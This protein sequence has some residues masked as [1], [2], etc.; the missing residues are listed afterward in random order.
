MD[1]SK[2]E[3]KR[4][5]ILTSATGAGHDTHANATTAWCAQFYGP[6]VEVIIDH[7]LEDSHPIYGKAVAFYNF[8]QRYMPWFHHIYYNVIE[9]LE[10]LN[11]G[12]VSLGRDYYIQLLERIR[13]HAVISVMDCLNRGYFELATSVLGPD[14]KCATY[15]TEFSD[16]YGHSRNWVNPRCGYFFGR[17]EDTVRDARRRGVPEERTLVVGHWA[18]P[19]FYVPPPTAEEK[20]T[21]LRDTLQLDADK[22][23]LLLSTGGNGAQNHAD[24]LRTLF[25]LGDRIQVIALCGRNA[26]ARADLDAWVEREAPFQVRTLPFTDE[27]AKLFH[28]SSAVVARG[29]ATSAGEVLLCNCPI[30]FNGLGLMMPQELPT[31]R[32]FRDHKIGFRA[33][34]AGGF[35]PIIERWLD[36]PEE[37]AALRQRMLELRNATTPQAALERLLV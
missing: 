35:R 17:T 14:T 2:P 31:W 24:I 9:L 36:H 25:P 26:K 21:Y 13:P 23:T 18:P 28:V 22:F 11:P 15:C 10:V 20:A 1:K 3:P 32:Y 37:Y 4:I 29:G 30:I 16:G 33:F 5:L 8:I 27:M 12:T 6:N 7:T 34:R 19:Q